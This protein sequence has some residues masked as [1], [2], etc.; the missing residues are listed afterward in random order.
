MEAHFSE[1]HFDVPR[2]SVLSGVCDYLDYVVEL[3]RHFEWTE[4]IL[5]LEAITIKLLSKFH[6]N[7]ASLPLR[8]GD[9]ET[10]NT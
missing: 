9:L 1:L 8:I 5:N 4:W 3:Q 6:S 10:A 2:F 7:Y